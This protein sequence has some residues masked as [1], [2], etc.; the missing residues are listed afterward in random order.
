MEWHEKQTVKKGDLGEAIVK[1]YLESQGLIV[2]KPLT[3][4]V[5]WFDILCTRGKQS[6]VAIDVKTKAR[7]NKW[8]AQG[9]DLRHY[10]EYVNFAESTSIE[11]YLIF[12]DDKTGEV[13]LADIMKLKNPIYPN[14]KIIAWELSE[15][16]Y[17]FT[18]DETHIKKLS[19]FDTRNYKFKPQ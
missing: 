9:I 15:M 19:S 3:N 13:H 10:K 2:Y 11:F 7:L 14:K 16:K 6:V 8:D 5:H 12:V 4:G 1:G 18:I 17:L